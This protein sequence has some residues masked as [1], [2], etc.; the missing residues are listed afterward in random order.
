MK[1]CAPKISKH[2]T[3]L[4]S[5][6][7]ENTQYEFPS[8]EIHKAVF[9]RIILND[10]KQRSRDSFKFNFNSLITHIRNEIAENENLYAT[11]YNDFYKS[12]VRFY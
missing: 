3:N 10:H 5:V 12:F 8:V 7:V 9:A 2:F 11:K 6:I 1:E 4:T